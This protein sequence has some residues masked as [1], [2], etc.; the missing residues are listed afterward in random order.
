MGACLGTYGNARP[1]NFDRLQASPAQPTSKPFGRCINMRAGNALF[2]ACESVWTLQG[3]LI[4][5]LYPPMVLAADDGRV[6]LWG[7]SGWPLA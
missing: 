1:V 5:H 4:V 6:M 2:S 3:E 7:V